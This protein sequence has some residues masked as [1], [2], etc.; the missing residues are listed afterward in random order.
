MAERALAEADQADARRPPATS[1]RCSGVPVAVKDN[2][3]V[4]GEVTTHGTAARRPGGAR[5]PS[6]S[7]ACARAGAVIIGKTNLPE[8]AI[9][10]TTESPNWGVTRNPWDPDRTPGGSSGGS[11]AAVAAGLCAAGHATDGAGSIRIPPPT[12]ACSGSSPSAAACRSARRRQHWHGMSVAGSV[13]R[14]VRD[15]ALLPGRGRG[16]AGAA[17]TPRRRRGRSPRRRA[18]RRASCGSPCPP[19][20]A[21]G[22]ADARGA[23]GA[24]DATAELLRGLGHEV[25]GARIPPTTSRQR[26]PRRATSGA[27]SDDAARC[28]GR[29]RLPRRTRGFARLGPLLAAG[30]CSTGRCATRRPGAE[31]INRVF[32][33]TTSLLTPDDGAR[34]RSARRSGRA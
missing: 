3:D 8:L 9:I 34:R 5:T 14:T 33:T 19:A 26:G 7:A 25:D 24:I 15:N 20:A 4:A 23:R 21:A 12:A 13:T 6:W 32:A 10:G 16:P 27:S 18:R 17:H 1:G 22:P 29:D 28:R 11:A 2:I 30:R 31:R